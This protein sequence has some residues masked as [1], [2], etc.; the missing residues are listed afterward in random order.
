[1]ISEL[2]DS[3]KAKLEQSRR[4]IAAGD[5]DAAAKVN[6][7]RRAVDLVADLQSSSTLN[8]QQSTIH[9]PSLRI[10]IESEFQIVSGL[11]NCGPRL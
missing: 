6:R 9:L 8:Y 4:E 10:L 3:V 5:H 2:T 11:T 1:M 7:G